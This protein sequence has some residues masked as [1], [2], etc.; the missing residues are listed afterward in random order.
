MKRNIDYKKVAKFLIFGGIFIPIILFL[1]WGQV[2]EPEGGLVYNL[3]NSKIVFRKGV[4]KESKVDNNDYN[5]YEE[6]ERYKEYIKKEISIQ[7]KYIVV[8]GLIL[9]I[10]GFFVMLMGG[11]ERF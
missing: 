4:P 1:I 2:Y 7:F 9:I 10:L 6:Y 5:V 8:F 3:K 11:F